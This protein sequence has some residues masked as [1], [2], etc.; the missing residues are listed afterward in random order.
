MAL[1][2]SLHQLWLRK[3]QDMSDTLQENA[4]Y[5]Q[6]NAL[7]LDAVARAIKVGLGERNFFLSRPTALAAS[8]AGYVGAA[9]GPQFSLIKRLRCVPRGN[10]RRH[11]FF[12]YLSI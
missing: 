12:L 2:S 5:G 3:L 1:C 11:T 9:A 10:I 8:A 6:A 7:K 4:L